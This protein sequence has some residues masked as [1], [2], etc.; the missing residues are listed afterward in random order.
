MTEKDWMDEVRER[1][2]FM[3]GSIERVREAARIDKRFAEI[4]KE[5]GFDE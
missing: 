1:F 2:P 4:M 3:E 5:E